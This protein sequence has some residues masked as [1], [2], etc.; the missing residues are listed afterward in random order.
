MRGPQGR[1][2]SPELR[3]SLARMLKVTGGWWPKNVPVPRAAGEDFL[4]LAWFVT[5]KCFLWTEYCCCCVGSDGQ[6]SS[7]GCAKAPGGHQA[8]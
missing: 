4:H 7:G 2:S 5:W 3:E 8:A 1:M 6:G